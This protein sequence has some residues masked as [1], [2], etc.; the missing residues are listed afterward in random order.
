M[1]L[2]ALAGAAE[3]RLRDFAENIRNHHVLVSSPARPRAPGP[4]VAMPDN[5]QGQR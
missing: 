2:R 3:T 1:C 5:V 4:S